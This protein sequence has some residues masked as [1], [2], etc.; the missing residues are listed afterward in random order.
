MIGLRPVGVVDQRCLVRA[1]LE[2]EQLGEL[3][4][5]ALDVVPQRVVVEQV[6]FL[7]SPPGVADHARGTAGQRER[8]MTGKLEAAH[9]QLADEVADVQ[10]IG[11]RIEA[12]VQP[13]A[14]RGQARGERI[15]ISRVVDEPTGV[16]VGK[17]VHESPMLPRRAV[18]PA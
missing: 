16:E 14:S 7:A 13:D 8:P 5:D 10:R 4:L 18:S 9:E 3:H 11:R 17:Q 15:A 6:A 12:D 2:V 1:G